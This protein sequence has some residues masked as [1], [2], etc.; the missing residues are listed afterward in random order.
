[1]LATRIYDMKFLFPFAVFGVLFT[2]AWLLLEWMAGSKPRAEEGL[3][4][5]RIPHCAAAAR[6]AT[7]A[8]QT[9]SAV[10]LK[11]HPHLGQAV[12]AKVGKRRQNAQTAAGPCGLSEREG[13]TAFLGLKFSCLL[14]GVALGG[15]GL[16]IFGHELNTLLSVGMVGLGMFFLP[17]LLLWYMGKQ[18]KQAISWDCP[19]RST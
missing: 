4:E 9:R 6:P 16:L 1:M 15:G 10:C 8:Q 13:A 17:D 7:A 19:M 18:R 3:E 5:M 11:G 12:A 14:M 2:S